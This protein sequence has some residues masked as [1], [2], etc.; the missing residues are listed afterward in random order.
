MV[1]IIITVSNRA[2]NRGVCCLKYRENLITSML[3]YPKKNVKEKK[4]I[5]QANCPTGVSFFPLSF[6]SENKNVHVSTL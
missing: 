2:L 1:L 4:K 6:H 3:T 5:F